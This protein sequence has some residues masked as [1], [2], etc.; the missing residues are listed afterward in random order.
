MLLAPTPTNFHLSCTQFFTLFE[1]GQIKSS[2]Q[3]IDKAP[4]LSLMTTLY[5]HDCPVHPRFI[6]KSSN[7][8]ELTREL[9]ENGALKI[10]KEVRAF[11]SSII[12]L[13]I[14]PRQQWHPSRVWRAVQEPHEQSPIDCGQSRDGIHSALL[15]EQPAWRVSTR[16]CTHPK[17]QPSKCLH[18]G[19]RSLHQHQFAHVIFLC[20]LW[21]HPGIKDATNKARSSF[22]RTQVYLLVYAFHET[23]EALQRWYSVE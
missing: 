14:H 2:L 9:F 13:T 4:T 12:S 8:M 15:G 20:L 7:K 16:G 23:L 11:S 18:L 19:L 17:L 21:Q 1:P 5:L 10:E 6:H 3:E 22:F